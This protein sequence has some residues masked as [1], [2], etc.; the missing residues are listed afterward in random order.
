[1]AAPFSIREFLRRA[2]GGGKK[3]SPFESE[4]EAFEFCEK[5]YRDTG[6]ITPELKR[7]YSFYLKNFHDDCPPAAGLS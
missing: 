4:Q 6:G 1:M 5:V 2:F 7:A 3:Q